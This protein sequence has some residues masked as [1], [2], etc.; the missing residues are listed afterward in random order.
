M[1]NY[2]THSLPNRLQRLLSGPNRTAV[3]LYPEFSCSVPPLEISVQSAFSTY[4]TSFNHG[5]V[6]LRSKSGFTLP[7]T[8]QRVDDEVSTCYHRRLSITASPRLGRTSNA[9]GLH[10][11]SNA[12]C[13]PITGYIPHTARPSMAHDRICFA[14]NATAQTPANVNGRRPSPALMDT[15]AACRF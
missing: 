4:V 1:P 15:A 3:R 14:T 9:A 5:P 6:L 11:L 8:D 12:S 10:S 13:D 7:S 2:G